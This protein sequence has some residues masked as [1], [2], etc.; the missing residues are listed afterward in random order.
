ME[1]CAT[2]H[3]RHLSNFEIEKRGN[4]DLG[5]KGLHTAK[6]VLMPTTFFLTFFFAGT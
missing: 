5:S 1:F 2:V 6:R 4:N 3:S